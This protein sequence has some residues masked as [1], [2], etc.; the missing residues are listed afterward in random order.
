MPQLEP[1]EGS[2]LKIERATHHAD[3]LAREV[4]SFLEERPF[5]VVLEIRDDGRHAWTFR[6]KPIPKELSTIVGDIVHNLRAALDLLTCDLVRLNGQSDKGVYFPFAGDAA[7]LEKMI[8]DRHIDRAGPDIVELV[9][10]M[11]PFKG[12]NIKL[13][14]IHDLDIT[15]K[16]KTLIPTANRFVPP[17]FKVGNTSF[18]GN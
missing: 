15:D 8:K 17:D 16:H 4:D 10:S 1:F 7:E 18:I 3:Q 13:R 5:R 14:A 9:R 6:T 12:G 2:K 11:K